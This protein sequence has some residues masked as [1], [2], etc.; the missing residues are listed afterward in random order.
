M[1]PKLQNDEI[2]EFVRASKDEENVKP[3]VK[4]QDWDGGGV[5]IFDDDGEY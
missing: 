5:M 4:S 1:E 3:K 2:E